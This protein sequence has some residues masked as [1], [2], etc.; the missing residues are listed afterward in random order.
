[1]RKLMVVSCLLLVVGLLASCGVRTET[2]YYYY[3]PTWARDGKVLFV[4]NRQSTDR[5]T[6]GSQLGSESVEYVQTIYPTG[7]G[8]SASIFETTGNP[9]YAMTCSPAGDFVAYGND[10]RLG[11]YRTL[12]IRGIGSGGG[13][14]RIEHSFSAGIKSFDW[15]NDGLSVVYCTTAEVRT[16]EIDGSND[17]LVTA[18][19]NI[20]FV[21]WKYGGRIAFVHASGSNKLLTLINSDGSGRTDLVAASSVEIPQISPTNTNEVYGVVGDSYKK[22]N[23]NTT[24]RTDVVALGFEGELPR[25]APDGLQLTY[26]KTGE[27]TG[28]YVLDDVTSATPTE[29]EIK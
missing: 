9:P 13:L 25:L 2:S 8:E 19:A 23:V 27:A 20:E 6:L 28:I 7:T 15:S 17:A 24:T 21:S 10:L 12:V 1:M 22:V 18:E 4:G 5:D 11:L 14:S 26:N 16:M 3:W 29:T